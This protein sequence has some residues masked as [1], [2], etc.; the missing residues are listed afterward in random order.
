MNRE[1]KEQE[2]DLDS[3]NSLLNVDADVPDGKG[4]DPAIVQKIMELDEDLDYSDPTSIL[5][6][7]I[8]RANMVLDMIQ[9][10]MLTGNFTARMVEVAGAII[11]G[12][13][14]AS[15]QIITKDNY[16]KYIDI[17]KEL[18]DLKEREVVVK[19]NKLV[20]GH[21]GIK[22]QQNIIVTSREELLKLMKKEE[23]IPVTE[24]KKIPEETN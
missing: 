18:K 14:A 10:E 13:T 6:V 24:V 17:R 5:R 12:V 23:P 16:D 9:V 4:L 7:N 20:K 19:E 3:L 15:Q 21:G 11:N 22:N 2:L 8:K 1:P